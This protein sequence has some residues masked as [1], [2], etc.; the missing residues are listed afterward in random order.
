MPVKSPDAIALL[1][2]LVATP[3]VSRNEAAVASVL[4]EWLAEHG[5]VAE[6]LGDGNVVV[7]VRGA[8]P[9]PTLLLNS[10]LDTVPRKDGWSRDPW[11][12]AIE[13][14]RLYGLGSN[15]AKASV[16]AMACATVQLARAGLARGEL[17]FAATAM[18]EVG[19]GGLEVIRGE[20]GDLDAALVG[21]P[22]SLQPAVAQG[23]LLIVEGTAHGR[24]AHAA[25]P[26][27]GLNALVAA[28]HD[29]LAIDALV[30]ERHHPFLGRSTANVTVLAGGERHNVIPDRCDYT[31]DVRY[32]PSYSPEELL[33]RLDTLTRSE[34]RV[35]SNRLRPVETALDSPIVT[36]MLAVRPDL[37][38]FGSP[39]MSDW[40]HLQGID[41]IKIGPG[42][43]VRS[44]TPDEWVAVDDVI[45]AVELYT[46]TAQKFMSREL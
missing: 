37:S 30:L 2:K 13:D 1:S 15:D 4:V 21:E 3:S 17:V 16:A 28:A 7:R 19:G 34:L 10:H 46:R 40:V 43:S 11:T 23:G 32:T 38:P 44:H 6:R 42:D 22:T 35:R 27:E 8:A 14:G 33:A 45:A 24:T 29:V 26:E 39:T 36:A 31:V 41:T 9:G 18:E 25:R 20:L 5:V 12:P